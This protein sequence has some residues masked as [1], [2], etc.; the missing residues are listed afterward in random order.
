MEERMLEEENERLVKIT[1]NA[2]GETEDVLDT[3]VEGELEQEEQTE[4]LLEFPEEEEFDETLAGLSPQEVAAE[5]ARREAAAREAQEKHD[6]LLSA[7]NALLEKE[8][9]EEA[10][11]AFEEALAYLSDSFEAGKGL[12]LARTRSFSNLEVFFDEDISLAVAQSSDEVKAFVRENAG[13]ELTKQRRA[14]EEEAQPIRE[15]V[16]AGQNERRTAFKAHRN[17]YLWR[18][19]GF[20]AC[21]ALMLTGALVSASFLV[22][23]TEITPTVLLITFAVLALVALCIALGFGRKLYLAQ[24]MCSDNEKLSSTKEGA[25]LAGIEEKLERLQEVLD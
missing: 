13:E 10:E 7:G 20:V 25:Y 4:V 14:L 16:S 23:T 11:E 6:E 1:K 12:W 9:F 5:L 18:T 15:R 19:L 3:L 21:F 24:K 2:N 22:R 17:Y 8:Q